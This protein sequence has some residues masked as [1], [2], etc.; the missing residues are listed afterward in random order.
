MEEELVEDIFRDWLQRGQSG[1]HFASHIASK[2]D[3]M[4]WQVLRDTMDAEALVAAADAVDQAAAEGKV[5]I[6]MFPRV[7]NMEDLARIIA[8]FD[9]PPRWTIARV[10]FPDPT[11]PIAGIN[12]T[13]VTKQGLASAAMGFAPCLEMPMTRRAPCVALAL[14]GGPKANPYFDRGSPGTVN[15]AHAAHPIPS[16]ENHEKVWK[17]TV[18]ATKDRLAI[19]AFDATWLREVSFCLPRDHVD[20]LFRSKHPA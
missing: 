9:H 19:P 7:R 4:F 5:A 16:R 3:L 2:S 20:S 8:N 13:F 17:T 18:A 6:L 14:W 12:V 1:C 11:N 15:M 10:A